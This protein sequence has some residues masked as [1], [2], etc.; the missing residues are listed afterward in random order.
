M[1]KTLPSL[2][3]DDFWRVSADTK[4]LAAA[5]A[6]VGHLT[7]WWVLYHILNLKSNEIEINVRDSILCSS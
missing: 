1:S 4:C 2:T 5:A 6:R 7:D 3:N